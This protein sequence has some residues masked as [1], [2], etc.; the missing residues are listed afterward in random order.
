M[1]Y[2][3]KLVNRIQKDVWIYKH[4]FSV[5]KEKLIFKNTSLVCEQDFKKKE[6]SIHIAQ[7]G[8]L[9][10]P[11]VSWFRMFSVCDMWGGKDSW[12]SLYSSTVGGESTK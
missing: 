9:T 12:L 5:Q 1:K 2:K 11:W 6:R 10:F 3:R 4:R 8:K 7:V